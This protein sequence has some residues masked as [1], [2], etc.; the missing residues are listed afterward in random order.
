MN[1]GGHRKNG[2]MTG[3]RDAFEQL[4]SVLVDVL[5]FDAAS[6]WSDDELLECVA[7]AGHGSIVAVATDIHVRQN[8]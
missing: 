3:T 2:P 7:G 8:R 6:R 5:R 4:S 1:V